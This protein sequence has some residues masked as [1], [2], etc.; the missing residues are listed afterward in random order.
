MKFID[1][2][3]HGFLDY[4]VGLFLIAAPWVFNLDPS[5]PEGM[6]FIIMGAAVIVYSII[7]NYELGLIKALSM[8]TH[9]TLDVLSGIVLAASPW[10]FGFAD[11]VYLPHLIL[12]ILEIGAGMMTKTETPGS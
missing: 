3:T 5:A 11:R 12:G 8:K 6:I 4:I 9:L 2:K 10:L 7:T 1:T